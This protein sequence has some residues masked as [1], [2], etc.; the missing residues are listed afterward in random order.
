MPLVPKFLKH[1]LLNNADKFAD[2]ALNALLL[3]DRVHF[4]KDKHQDER[5]SSNSSRPRR[6]GALPDRVMPVDFT[7]TGVIEGKVEFKTT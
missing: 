5:Q 6:G 1:Y 3:N 7:N 4:I 2:S